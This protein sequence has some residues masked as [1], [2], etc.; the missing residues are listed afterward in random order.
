MATP[1]SFALPH[2]KLTAIVGAPTNTMITKLIQEVFANAHAVPSMHGGGGHGH[3]GMIMTAQAY[4]MLAGATFQLPIHPGDTPNIPPC[5][6]S[7]RLPKVSTFTR[8]PL[9]NSHLPL[10]SVRK[11]KT[12]SGCHQALVPCNSQGRHLWICQHLCD[13]LD[14]TSQHHLLHH[15]TIGPGN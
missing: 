10:P 6:H 5:K 12:N 2:P 13:R 11:S 14:D 4:Q 15:H 8:L 3:L 9:P 1:T 7:M